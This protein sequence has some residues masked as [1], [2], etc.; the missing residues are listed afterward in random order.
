MV[1]K[2][3]KDERQAREDAIRKIGYGTVIKTVLVNHPVAGLQIH[4]ITD[5]GI[6]LVYNKDTHKLITKLIARVG[7]IK[8]YYPN[9]DA[10]KDLLDKAFQHQQLGLNNI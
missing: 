8:R 2:H 6:V 4:R 3:Y 9:G 5:T 10:P 1:S 7:Q